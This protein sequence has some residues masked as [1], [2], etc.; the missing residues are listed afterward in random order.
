MKNVVPKHV[1]TN[2]RRKIRE[3]AKEYNLTPEMLAEFFQV[4][5]KV[6][7]NDIQPKKKAEKDR[8]PIIIVKEGLKV[9][10][11][12]DEKVKLENTVKD[13]VKGRNINR[14]DW[15][16]EGFWMEPRHFGDDC[17]DLFL[18]NKNLHRRGLMQR[19][20][21]MYRIGYTIADVR[22]I[23]KLTR[24][25]VELVKK[26]GDEKRE[27]A[28]QNW[29]LTQYKKGNS[30]TNEK[31]VAVAVGVSAQKLLK[32]DKYYYDVLK[33]QG[34]KPATLGEP[35]RSKVIRDELKEEVYH[36]WKSENITQ[37]ELAE[38]YLGESNGTLESKRVTIGNWIREMKARE[39]D[40][41]Y[42]LGW[43]RNTSADGRAESDR[44]KAESREYFMKLLKSDIKQG[45]S[46]SS[47]RR[48]LKEK[49]EEEKLEAEKIKAERKETKK[50]ETKML[51]AETIK[52][53]MQEMGIYEEYLKKRQEKKQ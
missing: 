17:R 37:K 30:F 39:V 11:V 12:Y 42:S 19:A 38:K 16:Y 32:G 26:A 20:Y 36:R 41:I 51:A 10:C 35:K 33:K 3:F 44:D 27:D 7:K 47:M 50:I 48:K 4:P 45:A 6:I 25:E 5:V 29:A 53:Y 49:A 2:R 15:A 28:F 8:E 1:V 40:D 18:N 23:C 24:M 46:I 52:R 21:S 34:K 13:N 22:S 14:R 9:F 43:R 31:I